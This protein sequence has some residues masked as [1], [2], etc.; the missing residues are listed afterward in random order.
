MILPIADCRLPIRQ[1]PSRCSLARRR[2]YCSELIC[3]GQESREFARRHRSGLNQQFEPQCCFIRFL[4][5]RSN[6]GDE[7]RPAARST[8]GSIIC[9]N[10]SSAAYNLL[11]DGSASIV[12]PGNRT[13]HFDYAK[14]KCFSSRLQFGWVHKA[15]LQLRSATG[16][17]QSARL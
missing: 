17:R 1:S 2:H 6:L 9:R 3:F 12:I 5:H 15:T 7:F 16:N 13:R 10:R 8:T 14:R 11:G 4:L